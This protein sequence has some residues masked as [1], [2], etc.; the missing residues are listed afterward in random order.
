MKELLKVTILSIPLGPK[1]VR[2][3]SETAGKKIMNQRTFE[4][5]EICV[6]PNVFVNLIY[7]DFYK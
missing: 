3:A 7:R 1:L 5:N 6:T 4:K 2:M